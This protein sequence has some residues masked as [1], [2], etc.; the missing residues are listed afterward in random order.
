MAEYIAKSWHKCPAC[1]LLFAS[2]S[3]RGAVEACPCGQADMVPITE[4]EF[5]RLATLKRQS[6]CRPGVRPRRV[7][8]GAA[9]LVPGV[10]GVETGLQL[11]LSVPAYGSGR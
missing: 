7:S 4:R 3:E 2:S 6:A 5:N 8:V 1:K 9:S 10:G 11:R